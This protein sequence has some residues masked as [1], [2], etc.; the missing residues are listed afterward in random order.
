MSLSENTRARL[1]FIGKT[2]TRP[3]VG[4][5]LKSQNS[6]FKWYKNVKCQECSSF[7]GLWVKMLR[8]L[9]KCKL[10]RTWIKADVAHHPGGSITVVH[11]R[12]RRQ[13]NKK[14]AT[15]TKTLS[16]LP[17]T[18]KWVFTLIPMCLTCIQK[19]IYLFKCF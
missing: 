1:S 16:G 11:Y 9:F 2:K 4:C 15:N 8:W 5:W 17:L 10:K 12:F 13:I 19:G 18:A 3:V 6:F 14:Q 7:F